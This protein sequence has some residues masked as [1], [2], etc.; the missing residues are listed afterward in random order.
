MSES[1]RDILDYQLGQ[2]SYL[3]LED[4]SS[5]DSQD[6][7]LESIFHKLFNEYIHNDEL[8]KQINLAEIQKLTELCLRVLEAHD[9]YEPT[10]SLSRVQCKLWSLKILILVVLLLTHQLQNEKLLRMIYDSLI[11]KLQVPEE[12]KGGRMDELTQ[13]KKMSLISLSAYCLSKLGLEKILSPEEAS[14]VITD[15]VLPL[16]VWCLTR[17]VTYKTQNTCERFERDFNCLFNRFHIDREILTNDSSG[18]YPLLIFL[19]L[20]LMR[21]SDSGPRGQRRQFESMLSKAIERGQVKDEEVVAVNLLIADHLSICNQDNL[22]GNLDK[23]LVDV[24]MRSEGLHRAY[25]AFLCGKFFVARY[26]KCED[27]RLTFVNVMLDDLITKSDQLLDAIALE[28]IWAVYNRDHFST[29]IEPDWGEIFSGKETKLIGKLVEIKADLAVQ[30]KFVRHFKPLNEPRSTIFDDL[31][32]KPISQMLNDLH[33]MINSDERG[34]SELAAIHLTL[35]HLA[36]FLKLR[37]HRLDQH[38]ESRLN[39]AFELISEN[40]HLRRCHS[41]DD[42]VSLI[43]ANSYQ[44]YPSAWRLILELIK[45]VEPFELYTASA[46][47]RK[48]VL[49]C[50]TLIGLVFPRLL[51]N[52]SNLFYKE[53]ASLDTLQ[54]VYSYCERSIDSMTKLPLGS[55][56]TLLTEI[57]LTWP[58]DPKETGAKL[59][60]EELQQ[61]LRRFIELLVSSLEIASKASRLKQR[62]EVREKEKINELLFA[63]VAA[64]SFHRESLQGVLRK[65]ESEIK[66]KDENSWL[67]DNISSWAKLVIDNGQ[68]RH[69]TQKYYAYGLTL[70]RMDEHPN[71]LVHSENVI[72]AYEGF[73]VIGED[74]R[75]YSELK[76]FSKPLLTVIEQA[77]AKCIERSPVDSIESKRYQQMQASLLVD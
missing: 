55:T 4:S 28:S 75:P 70:I 11:E 41:M 56:R 72:A 37:R 57:L 42:A 20:A 5:L 48:E 53:F 3:H 13:V 17:E 19:L 59:G 46:I 74:S 44:V 62:P 32:R 33:R 1:F 45:F 23:V 61:M 38:E 24:L 7:H 29:F 65:L 68:Q 52:D 14:T 21:H 73:R 64:F 60:A 77:L 63:L 16:A 27:S 66:L 34:P 22:I 71:R 40:Q 31:T 26:T 54:L 15:R 30:S 51:L 2:F 10:Q 39:E 50:Q 35:E 43:F 36:S 25:V 47:D 18:T 12:E 76:Q 69:S 8:F 58:M 9:S 6:S 67:R 49:P